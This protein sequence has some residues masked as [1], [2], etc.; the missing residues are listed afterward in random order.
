VDDL[1]QEFLVDNNEHL[2]RLDSEL[3]KLERDRSIHS[4]KEPAGFWDLPNFKLWP[5]RAKAY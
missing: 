4:I 3:V 1:I 5:M 2:D